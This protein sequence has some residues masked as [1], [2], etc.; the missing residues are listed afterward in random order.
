LKK[1]ILLDKVV[2]VPRINL[3]TGEMKAYIIDAIDSCLAPGEYG[4]REPV[5]ACKE[6]SYSDLELIIAPGL[7]FTLRGERLGYGGGFYD[8]F[9]HDHSHAGTC[10]LTYNRLILDYLPVK[11]HDLPVDYLIT[12]SGVISI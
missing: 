5:S 12:E 4:I 1:S 8:R 6:L 2:A 7:G 10:S 3:A 11:N 9:K